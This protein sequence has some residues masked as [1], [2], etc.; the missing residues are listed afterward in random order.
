MATPFAGVQASSVYRHKVGA[1]EVTVLSDGNLALEA[2]LFSGDQAR[3]EKLLEAAFLPKVGIPTAVNEWL[4]NTGEKLVLVDTGASNVFAPTL[5]RLPQNLA[6]AGVD[7]SAVDA[8]VITHMHPDH[9]PGLLAAD[10]TM[11]FKNAIVHVNGDEYAFWTSD[12]VRAKAPEAVR[13]FFDLAK[14]AIRP[15][16]DAGKVQMHKDG[17]TFAPGITA[18]AAPG[19]T[20]GHT[21][22]RI[23]SVG[24]E[25]LLW[26][27][28]VHNAALQFPEPDRSIAFD[29]DPTM[30]I[31]NRK[32]VFEMVASEKLLFAGTHLP[33]PGVG[34]AVKTSS[35]YTYVPLPH[36]EHL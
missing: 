12:Q 27:D 21:M 31:A 29:H 11:M 6:A 13:P 23:S 35:G 15:Y 36:A 24:S 10:G 18:V 7:P 20:V 14:T 19:H 2:T 9:V 32:K 28:I 8:I 33:F 30:A 22:V 17:T 26:G 3:A 16:A 34:H 4:I 25:L 5:G 1:F